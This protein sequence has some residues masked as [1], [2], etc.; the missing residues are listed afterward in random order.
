MLPAKLQLDFNNKIKLPLRPIFEKDALQ[1]GVEVNL[2]PLYE[3]HPVISGNKWFK[4]KYNLE[5][6]YLNN[7][8]YLITFGG[9]YSN[10]LRAA[11]QAS[12]IY[13]FSLVVI[14]RGDD[15]HFS[16]PLIQDLKKCAVPIHFVSGYN[17]RNH[18]MELAHDISKQYFGT[19]YILPEGGSNTFA[20]NGTA[21]IAE[22]IPESTTNVCL[23]VGTGGTLAGLSKG[24]E[25]RAT[26]VLGYSSLKGE[27]TLTDDIFD[28]Q[29][30]AFGKTVPNFS[31]NWEF[32][33]GG[34]AKQSPALV[35][36]ANRFSSAYNIPL[37]L[38]YNAKMLF[39]LKEMIKLG[40]FQRGSE[41]VAIH[42]GGV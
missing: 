14:I 36:F 26:W 18:K 19:P 30:L 5:Q 37:E 9:G 38:V 4:L 25:A 1:A 8:D 27:D 35:G 10:H 6:F 29:E 2:L 17:Y 42:T 12:R 16:T 22:L 40:Y 13:G 21:E 33:F 24:L 28:M 32:N 31:L 34:Y 7:A 20:L 23:S 11:L 39:G 15:P 3:A 41:I